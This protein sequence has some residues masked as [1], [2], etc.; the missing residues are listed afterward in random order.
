M[1]TFLAIHVSS[2]LVLLVWM[3]LESLVRRGNIDIFEPLS[4]A[5]HDHNVPTKAM[6]MVILFLPEF[7]IVVAI[8]R[9]LMSILNAIFEW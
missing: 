7:V 8:L 6:W 4:E 1:L 2:I 3:V 9:L 5:A